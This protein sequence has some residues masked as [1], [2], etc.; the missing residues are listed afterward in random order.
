MKYGKTSGSCKGPGFSTGKSTSKTIIPVKV[1]YSAGLKMSNLSD[2]A[3][4][5]N[6]AGL[7]H[8]GLA[9]EKNRK[10]Q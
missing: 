7:K 9:Q 6:K 10:G 3:A 4:M 2:H 5:S 8:S 1:G